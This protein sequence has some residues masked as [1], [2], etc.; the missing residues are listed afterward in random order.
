MDFKKVSL[1]GF[2]FRSL[3]SF[4]SSAIFFTGFFSV[5]QPTPA[6]L[7]CYSQIANNLTCN[8]KKK[9]AEKT[10]KKKRKDK[11]NVCQTICHVF[12]AIPPPYPIQF[13]LF[14]LYFYAAFYVFISQSNRIPCLWFGLE[15]L[16]KHPLGSHKCL[17]R[18]I[19]THIYVGFA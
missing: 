1:E 7:F 2:C 18:H 9:K 5:V 15:T 17:F 10:H 11:R 16:K 8:K 4:L 12:P 13:L 6:P 19:H 14:M 3:L